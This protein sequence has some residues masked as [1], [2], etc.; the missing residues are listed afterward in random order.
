[1]LIKQ[2]ELDFKPIFIRID[3]KIEANALRELVDFPTLDDFDK[4]LISQEAYELSIELSDAFTD[5]EIEV[6]VVKE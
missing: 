2:D 5:C 3:T 1:M 6:P 4:G